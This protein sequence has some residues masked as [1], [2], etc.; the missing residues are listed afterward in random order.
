MKNRFEVKE[1]IILI[2]YLINVL[3]K[4]RKKAKSLLTNKAI[5]IN[6][7]NVTKYNYPL[8]PGNIVEIKEYANNN[9]DL[10][11]I[12]EDKFIIVVNKRSGLLTVST[13]N[14]NEKTLFHLVSSYVKEKNKYARIFVIHRLDKETSGIIMFAKDE[15]TKIMYQ[16]SWNELV[17]CRKYVAVVEGKPRFRQKQIIEYLIEKNNMKVYTTTPDKGK[18]AVTNYKIIRSNDKYSLLDI[19]LET[20]RKNQIRVAMQNIGNPIVGDK[21]YGS[22]IDPM[23]RLMLHAYNLSIINPVNKKLMTF[24]VQQPSSFNKLVK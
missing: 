9:L 13:E 7:S 22:K 1:T 5:Y 21:K 3:E 16:E 19:N 8:L 6:G 12:Y 17:K 20:G 10:D 23:K 2:D 4:P 14:E 11:I 24:E 15:N 18:K